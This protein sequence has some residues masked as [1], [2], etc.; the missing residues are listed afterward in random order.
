MRPFPGGFG[1]SPTWARLHKRLMLDG[2][3]SV[4]RL[5]RFTCNDPD[6]DVVAFR[7]R[8]DRVAAPKASTTGRATG[9][10]LERFAFD[11]ILARRW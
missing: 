3:R 8:I 2:Y 10:I 4:E 5:P 7:Q 1:N 6:C 11:K 9:W